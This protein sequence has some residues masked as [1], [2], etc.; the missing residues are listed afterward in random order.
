[1]TAHDTLSSDF[2]AIASATTTEAYHYKYQHINNKKKKKKKITKNSASLCGSENKGESPLEI[3]REKNYD[4]K[5]ETEG[6]IK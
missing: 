6:I 5:S 1:M 4:I 3:L 2:F